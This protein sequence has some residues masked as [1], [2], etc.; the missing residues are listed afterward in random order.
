MT[1]IQQAKGGNWCNLEERSAGLTEKCFQGKK[2]DLFQ[3]IVAV[4]ENLQD[5]KIQQKKTYKS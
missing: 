1:I 5:I 3:I 2:W 4:N